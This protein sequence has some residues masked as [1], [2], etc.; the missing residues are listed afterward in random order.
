MI[1]E[2]QSGVTPLRVAEGAL[3]RSRNLGLRGVEVEVFVQFGETLT[4][5]VFGGEVESV[6]AAEPRGMGVR[7]IKGGRVGYAYGVDIGPAGIDRTLLQ[8]AANARAADP[9]PFAGLPSASK[10]YPEIPGLW[11]PG[12]STATVES[13][14]QLA[15]EAE[16]AALAGPDIESVEES[17][18]TDSQTWVAVVSSEGVRAE[19]EES[20]CLAYVMAHAARD[21]DR[22][23]GLGFTMGRDPGELDPE[24]AGR[25]AARKAQVLLGAAPC[26]TGRYAVVFA[27]E[28]TAALLAAIANG[29]SADAVQKGR[30]VFS[31][32]IGERVAAPGVTLWDDGLAP[33]GP[34]TSPFDGEGVSRRTTM[35]V[36]NGILRSFLHNSYT[37]RKD[38]PPSSSTGNAT[39][40][41]YRSVPSLGPSNLVLRSGDGRVEDLFE[42]VGEGL[43][44][45]A[46]A[47]FHSGVN[48]VSGEISLGATGRLIEGGCAGR[49]VRE[50]TIA[51]DFLS[52]LRSV[53]ATAGDAG[54]VPL[55]GSA[56]VPS[57]VV[58][59]I[60]VSGK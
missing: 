21:G 52:L 28:V 60:A 29:L 14:I 58:E 8:A 4:V 17:E 57:I 3:D 13:K 53:V 15:L 32:R 47:G 43:Y 19:S 18:Y 23:S 10:S 20:F 24:S 7:V 26:S 40:T 9:D 41:S 36:E 27:R 45:E 31:G 34:A 12:I 39:R 37:G 33:G 22:Q 6:V 55:Y 54:W 46:V 38:S 56:H 35:L 49:P 2:G 11:L 1:E 51:T 42:K 25:D 48:A 5:K 44:V 30:S 59:D 50:V 16:A